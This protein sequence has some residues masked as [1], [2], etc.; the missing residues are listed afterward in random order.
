MMNFKPS[1]LLFFFLI[2]LFI[3]TS[4]A[5]GLKKT[6]VISPTENQSVKKGESLQIKY[7]TTKLENDEICSLHVILLS[8]ERYQLYQIVS[9]QNVD[10]NVHEVTVPGDHLKAYQSY[11][12]RK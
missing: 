6:K 9:D 2:C 4:E 12:I 3:I 8:P 10:G 11:F 7:E 5:D 1:S